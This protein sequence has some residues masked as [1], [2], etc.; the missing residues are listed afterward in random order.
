MKYTYTQRKSVCILDEKEEC[1]RIVVGLLNRRKL[2]K[3]FGVRVTLSPRFACR[4]KIK[5]S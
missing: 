4:P 3:G 5:M 2:S 1:R